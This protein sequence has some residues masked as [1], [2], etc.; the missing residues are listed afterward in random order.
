MTCF[1]VILYNL[2]EY[3][4]NL[5]GKYAKKKNMEYI[6]FFMLRYSK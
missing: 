1:I 5:H 2:N 6:I 4:I 3:V